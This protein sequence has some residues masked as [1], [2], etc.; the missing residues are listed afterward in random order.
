[1]SSKRREGTRLCE[2][3]QARASKQDCLPIS[4]LPYMLKCLH[5]CCFTG[6]WQEIDGSFVGFYNNSIRTLYGSWHIESLKQ[7]GGL[8]YKWDGQRLEGPWIEYPN[9]Q[10][11]D[12][13]ELLKVGVFPAH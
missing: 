10:G 2:P 5:C 3:F 4:R 8:A 13:M 7:F 6:E 1:M 11:C 9:N 12:K